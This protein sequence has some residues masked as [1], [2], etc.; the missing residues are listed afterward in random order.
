M[1]LLGL[2][3]CDTSGISVVL[4]RYLHVTVVANIKYDHCDFEKCQI[5]VICDGYHGAMQF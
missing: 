1:Q 5:L 2:S 4:L 3:S